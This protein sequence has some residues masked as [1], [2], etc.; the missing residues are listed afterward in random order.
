MA[1][2]RPSPEDTPADPQP[3]AA[4]TASPPPSPPRP[5]IFK[6][7]AAE[8]ASRPPTNPRPSPPEPDRPDE[9]SAT[10]S[11][12]K[13][14]PD[15][16]RRSG[17]PGRTNPLALVDPIK[18][19][20]VVGSNFANHAL[21]RDEDELEAGIYIADEDDAEKIARP[22]SRLLVRR[23][24]EDGLLNPDLADALEA[25]VALAGYIGKVLQRRAE[26]R[27]SRAAAEPVVAEDVAA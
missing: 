13:G 26:H 23:M 24:R 16:P 25:L 9:A 27:R 12:G 1:P 8:T 2:P 14:S 3:T 17:S 6:A 5:P 4:A 7:P 20:I 19:G 21:A 18:A 15:K 22:T 10:G 11:D